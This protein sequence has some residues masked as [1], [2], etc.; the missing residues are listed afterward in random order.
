MTA[1]ITRED[2]LPPFANEPFS[3]FSKPH[4]RAAMEAAL[5]QVGS[6]LG[7]EY[8]AY[9]GG[10]KVTAT[11][12]IRSIDPSCSSRLVGIVQDCPPE[13]G[14][15]AVQAALGAFE[16]WSLV[17]APERCEIFFRAKELLRQRRFE[18]NAW[19]IYEVGKNWAEADADVAEM[20][21]FFDYY[22][23]SMIR[24]N[25]P[26]ELVQVSEEKN[27]LAYIPLGVGVC[28]SP[29]NFPCAIMGG[30]AAAAAVAGNTVVSKPSEDAPV[31]ATKLVE[32]MIEAGVPAGVLNLVTGTGAAL[33]A[34]LVRHPKVRFVSFTGSREVGCQVVENAAKVSDGQRWLKRVVAE[35]GGK[36]AIIVADDADL[37]SAA[38]GVTAA[39][40]GYQGQKCSACSRV[41]VFDSVH[42]RFVEKLLAATRALTVG[43]AQ[44]PSTNV[45]PVIS[46]RAYEKVFH[47]IQLGK[48]EGKLLMGGERTESDG[49]FV[50]P[51]IFD[52]V[53]PGAR[54]AQ[55]EIFGPVLAVI[56][57]RDYDHALE[58][59]NGTAFG[60][61]G[62]VYSSSPD[63][64][65]RAAREFHVGN[66]YLNRKCTGA[67]VG[68][69]PFGGFNM[70]G[71]DSKT[72]GPDYLLQFTQ[73]KT[74]CAKI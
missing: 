61:T 69:H 5:A 4:V 74:V 54:I 9:I 49:F 70:S 67:M 52:E 50:P 63:R 23:R 62:A 48:E 27:R 18:F 15:L 72:G 34:H 28:I 11:Q 64:L 16:S 59:A 65:E 29:W 19:I 36:N 45:G 58:I 68:R 26:P 24:L 30:M 22:C 35:M 43:P 55:E 41:V 39:A 73:A 71:T 25:Q 7:R 53:R 1:K 40:F 13:L 38:Q 20:V 6:E 2:Q 42:D 32:L 51:T 44:D 14:D 12:K 60:L 57:A 10:Q 37:D 21:D 8:P 31:V 47:Y 56:R 33:G 17:P 46:G 3:D 66:L